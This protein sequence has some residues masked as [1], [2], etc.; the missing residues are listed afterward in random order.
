MKST[1]KGWAAAG[2]GSVVIAALTAL[3]SFK[4]ITVEQAG[5]LA[6]LV[7]AVAALFDPG[8]KPTPKK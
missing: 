5:P 1:K 7:V 8:H 6:A 4:V 3:A 2:L